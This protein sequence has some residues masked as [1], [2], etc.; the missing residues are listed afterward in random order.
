MTK[1]YDNIVGLRDR[2][3]AEEEQASQDE[4]AIEEQEYG[5]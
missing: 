2:T 5:S 1:T 4:N 3:P